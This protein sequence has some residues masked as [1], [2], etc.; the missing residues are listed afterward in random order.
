MTKDIAIIGDQFMLSEIFEKAILDICGDRVQCR[1]LD[2]GWPDDPIIQGYSEP[3]IEGLREYQGDPDVVMQHIGNAPVLVTHHAPVSAEMMDKMPDLKLIAV[4]RG[5]PVNVD[6]A[7]A[8]ARGI[9]VVNT[10]GRNASAVAE[11][12]IGAMIAEIRNLGRGHEAMKAGNYRTDL[13][14]ADVIGDELC[15][16]T[17]GVIGYGHIGARVVRILRAFGCRILVADPYVQLSA[18]DLDGG[19]E[20]VSLDRLLEQSDVVT[21]H[22]RVTP[23]TTGM[24]NAEAFAKMKKGAYVVNT[25]RGPLMDY[26]ALIEAL[27]SGHLRGAMLE[28]FAFEPVPADSPLLSLPNVTLTPHIAGASLRTVRVA[29]GKAAEEIRRWL[30]GEPPMNPS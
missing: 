25:A 10:P 6:V 15:D 20:Q 8:K 2:F 27:Q 18:D 26:D 16:M 3:R 12:T 5:G 28:T 24:M 23:E 19:V 29:A 13:Y 9:T 21:M 14:R 17:V 1:N 22:P 7:A 4:S 30:D 11:F